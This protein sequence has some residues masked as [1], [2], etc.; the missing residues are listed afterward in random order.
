MVVLRT[1]FDKIKQKKQFD[2]IRYE[3]AMFSY[4]QLEAFAS[5]EYIER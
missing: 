2:C 5:L 3:V 4:D 1:R